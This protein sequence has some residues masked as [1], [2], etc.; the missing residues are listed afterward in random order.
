MFLN[1]GLGFYSLGVF[2]IPFEEEF[3]CSRRQ[4]LLQFRIGQ[5]GWSGLSGSICESSGVLPYSLRR[6]GVQ[7][8]TSERAAPGREV[9][10]RSFWHK[11]HEPG[12]EFRGLVRVVLQGAIS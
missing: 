8:P 4:P 10:G 11:A 6:R 12:H 9:A 3:G 1:A 7:L 5:Y 2:I